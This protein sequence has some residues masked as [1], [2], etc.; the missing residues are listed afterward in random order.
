MFLIFWI[1]N[2]SINKK[3]QKEKKK[4]KKKKTLIYKALQTKDASK[5]NHYMHMCY[6][7]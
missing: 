4:E 3:N 5:Y 1:T 7:E 6:I 2:L